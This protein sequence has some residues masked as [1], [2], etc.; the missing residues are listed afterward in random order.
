MGKS[1]EAVLIGERQRKCASLVNV[2]VS[3][4]V[5]AVD[6]G[7]RSTRVCIYIYTRGLRRARAGGD[8]REWK[9]GSGRQDG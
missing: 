9:G 8:T 2:L 5:H 1:P 6:S 4:L 7:S 3:I